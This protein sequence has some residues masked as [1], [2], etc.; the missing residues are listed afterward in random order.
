M[1]LRVHHLLCCPL[2][3]GHGYSREFEDNIE[4]KTELLKS[5][6]SV[7]LVTEPDVI[8]G[9]CPNLIRGETGKSV[10]GLD[11]NHVADKDRELLEMLNGEIRTDVTYGSGELWRIMHDKMTDEIFRRSCMRC[12]WYKMGLCSYRKYTASLESSYL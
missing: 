9:S 8:C 10:C 5:G 1:E 11:G 6:C 12:E 7:R 4:N 3:T 2:Y